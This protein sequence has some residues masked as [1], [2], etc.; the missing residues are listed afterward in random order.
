MPKPTTSVEIEAHKIVVRRF[1]DECISSLNTGG[2]YET[3]MPEHRVAHLYLDWDYEGIFPG[4]GFEEETLQR[5][6]KRLGEE[7][8]KN[9]CDAFERHLWYSRHNMTD[10]TVLKFQV[11]S[12][13]TFALL[14]QGHMNDRWDNAC[15]LLEVYDEDGG[16]VGGGCIEYSHE[17]LCEVVRW[18]DQ[19]LTGRDYA[20]W[21]PPWFEDKDEEPYSVC[22][23]QPLWSEG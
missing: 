5:N 17:I 3:F 20:L 4:S 23:G 22:Y 9:I 18:T 11:D 21:S 6:V 14:L 10:I 19:R 7:F 8:P 16:L 1:H 13:N 2:S 12:Q 15:T